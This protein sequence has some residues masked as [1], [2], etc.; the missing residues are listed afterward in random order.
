[1]SL[2]MPETFFTGREMIVFWL[3]FKNWRTT[4]TLGFY[5]EIAAE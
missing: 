3:A 5:Y 2:M 4:E 1:M